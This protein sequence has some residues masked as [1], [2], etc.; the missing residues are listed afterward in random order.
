M[1][2][3]D[4]FYGEG[5]LAEFTKLYEHTVMNQP[6]TAPLLPA[7]AP[8]IENRHR[9]TLP[10]AFSHPKVFRIGGM[11]SALPVSGE[12]LPTG[13][14]G[15]D[16]E[17][18]GG[19]WMRPGLTEILCDHTGI[20]E[21]SLLL[22]GLHAGREPGAAMQVLWVT[23]P[24]QSWI[25]YAPGLV[26]AGIDLAHF[27]VARA[28]SSE[29]ALWVAEQALKSGACRCVLLKLNDHR[30]SPLSLRRLLQAAIAGGTLALL[31]R[32]LSAAASPSPADTR[33]ALHPGPSGSLRLALLKRRGLPPGKQLHLLTRELSCLQ[34]PVGRVPAFAGVGQA[35]QMTASSSSWLAGLLSASRPSP[36]AIRE[37]SVDRARR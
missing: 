8:A 36:V 4:E 37:R 35:E 26:Q 23:T 31:M 28:R 14:S 20:G 17:L 7:T 22:R 19:G 21:M 32:P 2:L 34:R 24:G 29:D 9:A 5:R 1:R 6:T 12:S 18:G 3:A 16:R 33:I 13:F 25:P 30:C 27:A 10:P 15:L 11:G